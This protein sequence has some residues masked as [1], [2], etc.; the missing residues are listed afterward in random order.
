MVTSSTSFSVVTT[1]TITHAREMDASVRVQ[2]KPEPPQDRLY[3]SFRPVELKSDD[4]VLTA[5]TIGC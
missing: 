5:T 4:E 1:K 2:I 3:G